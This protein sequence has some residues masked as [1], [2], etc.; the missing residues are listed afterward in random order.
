MRH[1]A[2]LSA[3]NLAHL[4]VLDICAGLSEVFSMEEAMYGVMECA[5]ALAE[6]L[7]DLWG[8]L[9]SMGSIRPVG[10]GTSTFRLSE[11]AREELRR[12]N[13][14]PGGTSHSRETASSPERNA[15]SYALA[16]AC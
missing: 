13:S 5:P 10:F 14:R 3:H 6:R 1:Q 9:F 4:Q 7:P 2:A 11:K 15:S 12:F 8:G 16:R